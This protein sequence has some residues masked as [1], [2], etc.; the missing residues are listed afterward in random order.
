MS[1]DIGVNRVRAREWLRV[2]F[3]SDY[4]PRNRILNLTRTRKSKFDPT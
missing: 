4:D 3:G 1:Y 2:E